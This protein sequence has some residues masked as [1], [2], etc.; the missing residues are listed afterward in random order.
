MNPATSRAVRLTCPHGHQ[1][2]GT[3]VMASDNEASLMVDLR[4]QAISVGGGFYLG[5]MALLRDDST[6]KYHDLVTN[7][8]I[9]VD[10]Q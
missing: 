3:L 9:K 4:G 1:V 5:F 2:D 10:L 8:E 6:G 7:T